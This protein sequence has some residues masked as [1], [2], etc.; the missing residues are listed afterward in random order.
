VKH[1]TAAEWDKAVGKLQPEIQEGKH[2]KAFIWHE[3][4]MIS[5]TYRSHGRGDCCPANPVM[6]Q[7]G[8][9]PQEFVDLRKCTIA[10]K[11]YIEIYRK[12]QSSIPSKG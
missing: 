8:L 9:S 11:E 4:K 2:R 5:Y 6:K 3:G 12:R 7:L 1:L 10:R